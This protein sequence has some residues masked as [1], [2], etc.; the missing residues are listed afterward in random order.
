MSGSVFETA[1]WLLMMD[2]YS[3]VLY[4][5]MSSQ[6]LRFSDPFFEKQ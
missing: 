6:S 1:S 5:V 4:P 3:H 2:T